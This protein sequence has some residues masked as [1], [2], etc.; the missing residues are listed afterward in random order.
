MAGCKPFIGLDAC[1]LKN[2]SRG[3]LITAVCRDPNDEYFPFAYVV[4][5]AETKD[6]WTWFL[7]LLLVDIG[8]NKRWVFMSDQQKVCSLF[9][10]W[11]FFLHLLIV[12]ISKTYFPLILFMTGVGANFH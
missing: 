4:V 12:S 3:Q 9:S 5:E 11:F 2:K 8:Q 10:I 7:N 6:C 1:H